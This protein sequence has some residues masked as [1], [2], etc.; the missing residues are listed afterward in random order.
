MGGMGNMDKI[1]KQAQK[2][3]AR[4]T[5]AQEEIAKMEAEGSAGGEMV[6]ARVN[7]GKELLSI[8]INPEAVDPDDVETLED[9]I[10]V[11]VNNAMKLIKEQSEQKMAEITGM[12]GSIPGMPF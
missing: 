5:E 12:M 4:M 2:M 1:L 7:G 9:L 3:Q 6:I 10:V 11:A 8:K